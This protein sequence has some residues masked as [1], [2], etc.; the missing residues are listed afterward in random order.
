MAAENIKVNTNN[1]GSVV[2]GYDAYDEENETYA[3]A[4]DDTAIAKVN[5]NDWTKADGY[6]WVEDIEQ[7][8]DIDTNL[9]G[10]YALRNSIDA[11]ATQDWNGGDGDVTAE[12]FKPIGVDEF[13]RVT[14][15]SV[16]GESKYGFYGKF[17][18]LDYNIFNLNIDREGTSHV[19]LFGV[20]HD[21]VINNVTFVGGSITGGNVVGSLAGVVVG[22]SHISNITNSASVTGATDVGGIVGYSGN[23]LKNVGEGGGGSR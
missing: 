16:N 13:G 14:V 19:G 3:G 8:Q 12:G 17:D 7:L 20:V 4:N 5:G 1:E 22:E 18:G 6:M 2:I 9:G 15:T 21:A 11:T 10:N 23:I